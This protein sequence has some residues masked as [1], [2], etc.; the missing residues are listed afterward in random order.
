MTSDVCERGHTDKYASMYIGVAVF[1]P[2]HFNVDRFLHSWGT[3][4]SKQDAV[5]HNPILLSTSGALFMCTN[6]CGSFSAPLHVMHV[7]MRVFLSEWEGLEERV[8]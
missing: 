7:C 3:I 1:I 5:L 2:L 6:S 4:F 8:T